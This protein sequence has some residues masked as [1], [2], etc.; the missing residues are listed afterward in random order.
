MKI[1]QKWS[2]PAVMPIV[3]EEIQNSPDNLSRA[4]EKI[5]KRLGNVTPGAVT[6]AWYSTLKKK[7]SQFQT[8]S[9]KTAMSNVK[10]SPRFNSVGQPIHQV[11]LSSKD[12][13]GMKV[14]TVKQYYAL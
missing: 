2:D 1:N 9:S 11:V 3:S 8:K 7:H 10:N 13:D 5:A 6:Q 12:F 14:V 4:F